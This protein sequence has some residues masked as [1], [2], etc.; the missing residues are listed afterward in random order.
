[1]A[2][3]K[4]SKGLN[5]RT[6]GANSTAYMTCTVVSAKKANRKRKRFSQRWATYLE[7]QGLIE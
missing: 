6:H 2:S 1:M 5:K 3:P 7:R 4:Q